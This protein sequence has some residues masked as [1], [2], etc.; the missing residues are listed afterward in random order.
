M[1]FLK[2]KNLFYLGIIVLS[3]FTFIPVLTNSAGLVPCGGNGEEPCTVL[4][5]F[6]LVARVTNWLLRMAGAFAVYK[7]IGASWSLAISQGDEESI[8]TNKKAFTNVVLGFCL[9]MIS[10]MLINTV[11]NLVLLQG[12]QKC[13]VDL[14][15]AWKYVTDIKQQG[16]QGGK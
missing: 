16:C 7:I 13:K 4:H 9:T 1:F 14:T 2:Q 8:T 15:Q 10:F 11:V 12:L 6:Y 3:L 5:A